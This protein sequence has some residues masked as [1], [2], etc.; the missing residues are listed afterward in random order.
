MEV[1]V[2]GEYYEVEVIKYYS[3]DI[4]EGDWFAPTMVTNETLEYEVTYLGVDVTGM[5]SNVITEELEEAI[6]NKLKE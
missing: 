3:G 6:I 1:I 2:R 4:D 5:L